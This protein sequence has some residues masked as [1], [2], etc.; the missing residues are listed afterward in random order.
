PSQLLPL[1]LHLLAERGLARPGLVGGALQPDGVVPG[2][3]GPLLLGGERLVRGVGLVLEADG[4]VPGVLRPFLL[5]GQLVARRRAPPPPPRPPPSPSP[6]RPRRPPPPP[7]PPPTTPAGAEGRKP[8]PAAGLRR[9]PR[10]TRSPRPAGRAT[11]GSPRRNRARSS[12]SSAA[13][14]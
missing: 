8:A 5:D 12:A 4:V 13:V 2:V 9:P 14:G 1:P 11:I 10:A 7:P 6:P 3:V